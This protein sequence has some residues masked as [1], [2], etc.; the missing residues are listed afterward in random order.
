MTVIRWEVSGG[1]IRFN[2][3]VTEEWW[4]LLIYI[5]VSESTEQGKIESDYIPIDLGLK[6]VPD[7]DSD[8]QYQTP[9]RY[10]WQEVCP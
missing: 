8:L 10:I 7:N 2:E 9:R 5:E 3:S 4:E 6:Y 1:A